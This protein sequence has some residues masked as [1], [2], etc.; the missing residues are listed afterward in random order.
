[1]PPY[2]DWNRLEDEDDEEL[3]DNTVRGFFDFVRI[4]V[5][6]GWSDS[7]GQHGGLASMPLQYAHLLLLCA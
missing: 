6:G 2:D 5:A 4:Y 7:R 3:Q 1:M